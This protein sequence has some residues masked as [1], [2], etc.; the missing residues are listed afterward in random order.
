MSGY[1]I[2][3]PARYASSR[4]PGKPLIDLAGKP[5]IQHVYERAQSAGAEDI[6]IATDDDR[7][8]DVAHGFGADVVMTS[9]DHENGTERIAEVVAIKGWPE[10]TVVVNL[11]G[12]EPLI[13]K[14]LIELTAKGL[15]ENSDAGMSSVCTPIT[16][17][18]DAFDPNVVKVVLNERHFAMYFSRAPIPW[19]RDLYKHGQDE[20]TSRLPVFRH[21]GMYGYRVS[22]LNAYSEMAPCAIELTESLEQLRALWYGVGIHMSVI[23]QAPG[24]GI[25]TPHDVERVSAILKAGHH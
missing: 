16:T 24:H 11:Q 4:L 14:S 22:F 25:D 12:D 17:A 9:P 18:D 13:P 3:I 20:V 8:A 5:M 23:D 2:V 6:V 19:D 7:I 21:I 10:D 1:K 15:L